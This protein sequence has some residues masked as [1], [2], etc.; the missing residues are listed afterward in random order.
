V[1][2]ALLVHS[3]AK[4]PLYLVELSVPPVEAVMPSISYCAGSQSITGRFILQSMTN[5]FPSLLGLCLVLGW[6]AALAP[7]ELIRANQRSCVC[8]PDAAHFVT[9]Q[10]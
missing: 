8:F 5:H 6:D 4:V 10:T 7:K 2:G 3:S 9:M 1:G